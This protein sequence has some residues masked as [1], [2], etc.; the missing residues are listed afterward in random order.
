MKNI[1]VAVVLIAVLMPFSAYGVSLSY[2]PESTSITVGAG[3]EAIAPMSVTLLD[4]FSGTYYL[5]FT[6]SVTGTL[7]SDWVVPSPSTAFISVWSP[8]K[9]TTLAIKV[10]EDAAPGKYSG[11]IYSKAM[12]SHSFADPGRGMY[13]E[14]TVP[15]KCT[16]VPEFEITSFGPETIWPPNRNT[17]TVSVSGK[18]IVPDGCTLI[19]LGYS[20][21]DEYGTYTSTG[22]LTSYGGSFNLYIPVEAWR[23]GQDRDGRH[24]TIT[25]YAEDEAGIGNSDLLEAVVPHDQ[26]E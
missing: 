10:P 4:A 11:Y 19:E 7:P 6:N 15:A 2:A 16:G 17:E 1:G 5:W 25:I 23:K 3:T 22:A 8:T 13:M 24:Y 20:V 18:V 9:S 12:K 21:D 26:R 14:V